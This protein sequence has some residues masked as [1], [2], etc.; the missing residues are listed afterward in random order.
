MREVIQR[1]MDCESN[2]ELAK[3]DFAWLTQPSP[4]YSWEEFLELP[5]VS[6]WAYLQSFV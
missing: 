2:I 4:F 1:I 5:R 3:L 6:K